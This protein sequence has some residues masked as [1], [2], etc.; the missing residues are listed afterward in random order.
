VADNDLQPFRIDATTR[1]LDNGLRV[2][3][4]EDRSSPIVAVH[5]MYHAGSR[6]EPEG[7]TGLAHLLEHLL[8]EGSENLAKGGFDE[9]LE[10]V[11]GTSNGSTW[12]D[13][14]NYFE[15]VPTHAVELPLW[16]ER[17]RLAHFLPM[18][19]EEML[20]LQRD[21]VVN[22]RLQSTES[23]PYGE[24][25]ER[26]YRL[27][28]GA[29]HPY[30]WPV[31][32]WMEDLQRISLEDARSF[33]TSHYVPSNLVLVLAGDIGSDRGFD[34]AERYFGDLAS[35]PAPP[36]T[37][38]AATPAGMRHGSM[39]DRV[40]FPRLYRAHA[41][42]SYGSPG[43]TA[44][45][46]LAYVL[47]DG[48]SSRLQRALVRDTQLA[49]EVDTYLLPTEAA[50]VF[51]MVATSRNGVAIERIGDRI[52]RE[53]ARIAGEGISEEELLGALRRIRSDQ[54]SALGNMEDR[55]E[56]LAHAATVLDD[57]EALNG[58]IDSYLRVDRDAV[59]EAAER[60][61]I[62]GAG[63]ALTVVPKLEVSD[64]AA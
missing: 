21:V 7:R 24:A 50:G 54:L 47:A 30:G 10:Q 25:E 44:V 45:D 29:R 61:L 6:H 2:V 13:R 22:E 12:L 36:R 53:V 3:V 26:L 11:G 62:G 15:T 64:E 16:L 8:F 48:E 34:L 42:P 4:H 9:L 60:W 58:V 17:E 52:D 19:D 38:V 63:A 33:F 37:S 20:A 49:Q 40:S 56:A 28:F 5:L 31:I 43:W 39:P 59:V 32:G 46:V 14:T 57:A 27:L 23:R 18:L 35:A 1:T 55:A 41:V 51:G